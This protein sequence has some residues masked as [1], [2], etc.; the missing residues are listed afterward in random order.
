M[1]AHN[2]L[3]D[4][5]GHS[6]YDIEMNKVAPSSDYT[7]YA[8]IQCWYHKKNDDGTEVDI[9][10]NFFDL[11]HMTTIREMKEKFA[12]KM[13]VEAKKIM[14]AKFLRQPASAGFCHMTDD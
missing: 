10:Q 11:P 6:L 14:K 5:H 9:K 1:K 12:D 7:K 3:N 13:G 4:V 2:A 8:I